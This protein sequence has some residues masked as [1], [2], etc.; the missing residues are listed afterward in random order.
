V[1]NIR[2]MRGL[3]GGENPYDIKENWIVMNFSRIPI[4]STLIRTGQGI[5]TDPRCVSKL[6]SA[7]LGEKEGNGSSRYAK[8]FGERG[9]DGTGREKM[10]CTFGNEAGNTN[11]RKRSL[12][13]LFGGSRKGRGGEKRRGKPSHLKNEGACLYC[14]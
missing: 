3:R 14:N 1:C 6:A 5:L 10:S 8:N 13:Q 11:S 7:K 12:H 4:A 9:Q 2:W